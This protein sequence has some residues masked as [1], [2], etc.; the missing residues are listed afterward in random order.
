MAAADLIS[1][2]AGIPSHPRATLELGSACAVS[3]P[4]VASLVAQR[5]I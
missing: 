3:E 2:L 4:R 5:A 1:P